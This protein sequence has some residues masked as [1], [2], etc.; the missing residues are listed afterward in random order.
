MATVLLGIDVGTSGCKITAIDAGGHLLAEGAGEYHTAHP[1]P[2]WSEED[3]NEWYTVA[4]ALLREMWGR[5]GFR[6]G[7]VAAVCLDGSTHNAVLADEAFTPLRPTIMWTDQRSAEEAAW[8]AKEAGEKIFAI[9]YQMPTP[10]W[11]LPQLLW[12]KKHDPDAFART[13]RILFTKDYVRFRLTGTWET[14][15]IE[16]Q[17]SLFYDMKAGAWSG[18]LCDLIGL[19][20][21]ALPPLVKPTHVA[22][23]VTREAAAETGLAQGT[24]V[25]TG[26]SDSAIED[27]AAGA[28]EPGQC[29]IKL[30]TAGNVNIMTD[31]PHPHPRTLTYSHVIPGLWYTVTATNSAALCQR[32]FR[33]TFC[34]EQK[35]LADLAQ[36]NI[37]TL[38]DR[39]AEASPLGARGLFFHPY[40]QG[41]R[42]P[43]WDPALRG[44]FTGVTIRHTKADFVRALMEGVAFSLRDCRRTIDEMG[45]TI[46]EVRLIGGGARSR[47]WGRIVCDV[48]GA[49][50]VCP[51]GCD[52]SFGSAL[53]AGVGV[54]VF[55]DERAAV[56]QCV[57]SATRLEPD[58][59]A[60]R[61][62]GRLFG[63]YRDIHD[64]LEGVCHRIH[65]IETQ[66][67]P[68]DK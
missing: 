14:D 11:T 23:R 39:S 55:K 46:Q 16:A 28:V 24:P 54:G 6:P 35:R 49:P 61:A 66:G 22:G 38:M 18:E 59:D 63:I 42:S 17:G 51:A 9:A 67:N 5:T 58:P 68:D 27:Y 40:L 26:C 13:R 52:A 31:R 37:Y 15:T 45:L 62:Y 4:C 36:E 32:W 30:A 20:T 57:K 41:E 3:P 19:S 47:L 56:A 7:D 60:V 33:D 12:V 1:Y 21:K 64:A 48:F 53:L 65:E 44:S 43:Y 2:G 34:E 29:V 8:L 50:L 10:T 25:V